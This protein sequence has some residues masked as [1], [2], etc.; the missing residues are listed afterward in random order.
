[1][2]RA[3]S[4]WNLL[5]GLGSNPCRAFPALRGHLHSLACDSFL[6]LQSLSVQSLLLGPCLLFLLSTSVIIS[7]SR[8]LTLLPVPYKK[9]CDDI[10]PTQTVQDHLPIS[11]SFTQSHLQSGFFHPQNGTYSQI[12]GKG[13]GHL[14]EALSCVPYRPIILCRN[15]TSFFCPGCDSPL[16]KG[17]GWC[18][19]CLPLET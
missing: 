11:G 9:P 10:G 1:M 14:W 15:T 12:P 6:C 5:E 16:T 18:G 7:P 13:D 2:I 17:M 4:F 8:T 19:R 3:G